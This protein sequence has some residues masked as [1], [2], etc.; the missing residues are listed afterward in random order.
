MEKVLRLERIV[1]QTL[2]PASLSPASPKPAS[3]L[4][5]A[6]ATSLRYSFYAMAAYLMIALVGLI[7]VNN[8]FTPTPDG[9]EIFVISNAV[10]ADI[11]VP[12]NA[13]AIDWRRRFP[14]TLF[15][16]NTAYATH[17]AIGW[18][19]RGFFLETPTWSDL[20]MTTAANA[21]LVP[22]QSCLHVYLTNPQFLTASRRR[23]RISQQQYE[24]LCA[25]IDNSFSRDAAD[26]YQPIPG[27]SYS[28]SDAF[29]AANGSYHAFA[30]CNCWVG[31]A[32][33]SAGVRCGWFTPLPKS[34]YLYLN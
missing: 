26:N 29:F 9:I 10:H 2:S 31:N 20:K 22:S 5:R 25:F 1:K 30:T 13:G 12:I 19:D 34:V 18:G 3:R 15:R 17:A 4:L 23:V 33:R 14:E 28:Q 8:H 21:L 16:G 27:I 32:L 7:P 24:Q 11:V 6:I